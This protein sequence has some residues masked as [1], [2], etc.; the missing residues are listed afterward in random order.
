MGLT[1]LLVLL[2]FGFLA[3][4]AFKAAASN[5]SGTIKT[6]RALWSLFHK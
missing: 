6:G 3:S 1:V 5:P 2:G 4:K